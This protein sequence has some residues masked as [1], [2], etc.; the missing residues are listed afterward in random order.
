MHLGLEVHAR[1]H[2]V[3][4]SRELLRALGSL[5]LQAHLE[6]AEAVELHAV[7]GV[8][9]LTHHHHELAEHG[10]DV[11]LLRRHVLLDV[12]GNLLQV[13]VAQAL[14]LGVPLTHVHTLGVVL[15]SEL[16]KYWHNSF[17]FFWY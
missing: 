16:I 14:R 7:A 4:R 15:L 8:E 13:P 2:D 1:A 17:P 9:S 3:L 12:V 6:A 5:R 11:T 10:D